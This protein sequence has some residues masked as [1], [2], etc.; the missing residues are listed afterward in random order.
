MRLDYTLYLQGF[1]NVGFH[2]SRYLSRAGATLT[3]VAEWDGSI[4]NPNGIDPLE[5]DAYRSHHVSLNNLLA[6]IAQYKEQQL[7]K[8]EFI[9]SL[10]CC[11]MVCSKKLSFYF[12]KLPDTAQ[13]ALPGLSTELL[14][15][16]PGPR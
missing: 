7:L 8:L 3:G 9:K 1:G 11:F 15:A 14:S 13:P 6:N 16:S 12:Q 10:Q 2:T 4:I 5:L